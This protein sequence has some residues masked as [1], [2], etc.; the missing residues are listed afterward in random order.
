[1]V[2]GD[3]ISGMLRVSQLQNLRYGIVDSTMKFSEYIAGWLND[4]SEMFIPIHFHLVD[5][6]HDE[7]R[8]LGS[9]A[10][11]FPKDNMSKIIS[12][13]LEARLS[14]NK[15]VNIHAETGRFHY[16]DVEGFNF[17]M[18]HGD[19]GGKIQ[20][21]CRDAVNVYGAP[22]DYFVC[23]HL[24][25]EEEIGIGATKD[26]NSIMIRVPSVCGMDGYAQKLG[27]FSKPGAT[28]MIIERGYGRRCVYPILL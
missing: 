16:V 24:H 25:H 3:C 13:Y 9:K 17:L 6:N 18:L 14:G 5:G 26:G 1:M 2:L 7:V 28:A 20:D 8:P 27:R 19:G 22:I 12:W 21:I 11:D 10:G 23:G 15:V 4:L